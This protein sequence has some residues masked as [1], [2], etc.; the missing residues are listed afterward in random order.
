MDFSGITATVVSENDT[1]ATVQLGGEITASMG[2]NEITININD[3]TDIF[4]EDRS[5]TLVLENNEWRVCEASP[6]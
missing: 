6:N 4:G 2:G 3:M 5:V 1:S